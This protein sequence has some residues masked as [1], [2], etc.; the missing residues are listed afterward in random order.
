MSLQHSGSQVTVILP[1]VLPD[2]SVLTVTFWGLPSPHPPLP[3]AWLPDS[4]FGLEHLLFPN[5]E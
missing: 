1:F 5:W 3:S 4:V 2:F